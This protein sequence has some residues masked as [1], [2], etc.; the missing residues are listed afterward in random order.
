ME[1]IPK[2]DTDIPETK[3]VK[4]KQGTG[5]DKPE[6]RISIKEYRRAAGICLARLLWEKYPDITSAKLSQ[7]RA[8]YVIFEYK[9]SPKKVDEPNGADAPF[10]FE[11][12]ANKDLNNTEKYPPYNAI[13]D[14]L[15]IPCQDV[16]KE[17]GH[18]GNKL[19]DSNEQ[20]ELMD[21]ETQPYIE[22]IVKTLLSMIDYNISFNKCKPK[23]CNSTDE[24][25]SLDLM[26]E[27]VEND[28]VSLSKDELWPPFWKNNPD[29]VLPYTSKY[30][31][32]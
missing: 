28:P 30:Q 4:K 22:N 20:F 23:R 32:K 9:Y 5:E 25:P 19:C 12:A 31:P 15:K 16:L 26:A 1:I 18:P 13:N 6:R 27:Y 3:G 7:F 2:K 11:V 21:K 8:F 14:W 17:S 29:L 24:L 10:R